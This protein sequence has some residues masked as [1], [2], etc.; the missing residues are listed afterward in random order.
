MF[1]IN[2]CSYHQSFQNLLFERLQLSILVS[3]VQYLLVLIYFLGV[4]G[5]P[6]QDLH[7]DV[8]LPS[9]SASEIDNT[10]GLNQDEIGKGEY[11]NEHFR[12]THTGSH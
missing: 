3:K 2:F 11:Y 1:V 4:S 10:F 12:N 7:W 8:N 5:V 9:N 6:N